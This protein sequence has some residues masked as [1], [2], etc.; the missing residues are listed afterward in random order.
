MFTSLFEVVF[1]SVIIVFSLAMFNAK[2][3]RLFKG[4]EGTHTH[5][6]NAGCVSEA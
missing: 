2:G 1:L 4:T 3:Y 5:E 6:K